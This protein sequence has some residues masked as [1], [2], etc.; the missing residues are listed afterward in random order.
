[1]I[2]PTFA[3][4][5]YAKNIPNA[6]FI[7]CQKSFLSIVIFYFLNSSKQL[8]ASYFSGQIVFSMFLS[9]RK[10]S[11]TGGAKPPD[12]EVSLWANLQ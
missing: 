9:L 7:N 1:M 10:V 8:S 2:V 4:S 12:I 6:I 11:D 5:Q 3:N